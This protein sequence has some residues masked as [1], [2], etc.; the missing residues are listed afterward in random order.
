MSN[1]LLIDNDKMVASGLACL[2]KGNR[3]TLAHNMQDMKH[4]LTKTKSKFQVAVLD[5]RMNDTEPDIH[6]L[7][8]LLK[9]PFPVLVLTGAATPEELMEYLR[10]GALGVIRK[11][12]APEK[13][14]LGIAALLAG[15]SW[16]PP[17]LTDALRKGVI[18]R[19]LSPRQQDILDYFFL[20][21]IPQNSQIAESEGICIN[22]VRNYVSILMTACEV[23][24]RH[25][26]KNKAR[27]LGYAPSGRN[28]VIKE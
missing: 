19:R 13:L 28:I 15:H 3:V 20:K 27:L 23:K 4:L 22:T 6:F 11:E 7:D 26:I 5:V 2:L 10:K 18:K 17:E 9:Q 8:T 12:D 21:E 14:H 24:S 16:I 1:I 25:L